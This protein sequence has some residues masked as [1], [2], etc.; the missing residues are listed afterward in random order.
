MSLLIILQSL[1]SCTTELEFESETIPYS[2]DDLILLPLTPVCTGFGRCGVDAAVSVVDFYCGRQAIEG[3]NIKNELVSLKKNRFASTLELLVFF[4]R[5]GIDAK[6]GNF[7]EKDLMGDLEKGNPVMV[8]LPPYNIDDT[9]R[10]E[11]GLLHCWLVTG[12]SRK[13]R[14]LIALT[15]GKGLIA[16]K[17]EVFQR[18]WKESGNAAIRFNVKN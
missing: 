13:K 5:C 3:E 7:S 4:K 16:I 15:H 17:D 1:C 18:Y 2:A 11:I 8:F 14:V 6:L 10:L 12:S 9:A